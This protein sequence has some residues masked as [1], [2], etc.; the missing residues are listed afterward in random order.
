[1]LLLSSPVPDWRTEGSCW[2][3]P[4]SADTGA[5]RRVTDVHEHEKAVKTRFW[6]THISEIVEIKSAVT[7]CLFWCSSQTSML[8]HCVQRTTSVLSLKGHCPG[9]T[10]TLLRPPDPVLTSH[11]LIASGSIMW[12]VLRRIGC[13]AGSK[14]CWNQFDPPQSE[15][16]D[17]AHPQDL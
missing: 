9:W 16:Q 1:M 10:V 12:F 8:Q 14:R 5:N 15:T 13:C 3:L 2:K 6:T 7:G 11:H 17:S 4:V